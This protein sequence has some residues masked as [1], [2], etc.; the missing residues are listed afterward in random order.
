MEE[1]EKELDEILKNA[2]E[3][4]K[5]RISEEIRK[6]K[7]AIS[8]RRNVYEKL[9][10]QLLEINELTPQGEADGYNIIVGTIVDL[11]EKNN[12]VIKYSKSL[13]IKQIV[14]LYP[15]RKKEDV[16]YLMGSVEWYDS[17]FEKEHQNDSEKIRGIDADSLDKKLEEVIEKAS[18]AEER[19]RLEEQRKQIKE[20]IAQ[21]EIIMD[22]LRKKFIEI[23]K[24]IDEG[25]LEPR[26]Y[27]DLMS[28][29]GDM[30]RRND[31]INKAA[32]E[33]G[34]VLSIPIYREED[35]VVKTLNGEEIR[36]KIE[37]KDKPKA[38]PEPPKKPAAEPKPRPESKPVLSEDNK[39]QKEEPAPEVP[40]KPTQKPKENENSSKE[41]RFRAQ[42]IYLGKI[43]LSKELTLAD[44]IY[45]ANNTVEKIKEKYG[46]YFGEMSKKEEYLFYNYIRVLAK[47]DGLYLE[48]KLRDLIKD[49]KFTDLKY[50]SGLNNN[51]RTA[52][53]TKF[54]GDCLTEKEVGDRYWLLMK[55]ANLPDI[56]WKSTDDFF[57]KIEEKLGKS[58]SIDIS[59][60][61][62]EGKANYSQL[63]DDLASAVVGTNNVGGAPKEE[64][65]KVD[66]EEIKISIKGNKLYINGEELDYE[67]YQ[68]ICE[69]KI[70]KE[71][72]SNPIYK[73][74]FNRELAV[75]LDK[76]Q[77]KYAN[78]KGYAFLDNNIILGLLKYCSKDMD[79]NNAESIEKANNKLE[80][81]L[82][83][84]M[85]MANEANELV[86]STNTVLDI[87]YDVS[88]RFGLSRGEFREIKEAAYDSK[89]FARV[90]LSKFTQFRWFMRRLDE[91]VNSAVIFNKKKQ[92][93][94][95]QNQEK[96]NNSNA[97]DTQN[98][99]NDDSKVTELNELIRL[100]PK[101]R[102]Y[103]G[104]YMPRKE[105]IEE[106]DKII[107]K[108]KQDKN[109]VF[110]KGE[111]PSDKEI[112]R[113]VDDILYGDDDRDR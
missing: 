22:N 110:P 39:P 12:D 82:L 101:D 53:Y 44:R 16:N 52:F 19:A 31:W 23:K 90:G 66:K 11:R 94:P 99:Q 111:M 59:D 105:L 89:H 71:I 112:N 57:R 61:K 103:K 7:D 9:D 98:V 40:V 77:D 35:A 73:K 106:S 95:A 33:M 25:T 97:Q 63:A 28:N 45:F 88:K 60:I 24:S 17:H 62:P 64:Q 55:Y 84:Y 92:L 72:E 10:S 70:K 36:G 69:D 107:E 29:L 18:S 6:L 104:T 21:K 13:G 68:D 32:K 14:P 83:T 54:F 85:G 102:N 67:P 65:K 41:V 37:D 100:V 91:I 49:T 1:L 96:I 113:M 3:E 79:L 2:S 76:M 86:N 75:K 58:K 27:M 51:Y 8:A 20:H 42:D 50:G 56:K 47:E 34:I 80:N 81:V 30:Q 26:D 4:D 108:L 15:S 48:P 5:G 78:D 93:P 74:F 38:K 87:E 43:N 109:I 46:P